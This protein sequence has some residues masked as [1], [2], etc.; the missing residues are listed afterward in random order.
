LNAKPLGDLGDRP[1][2]LELFPQPHLVAQLGN[3]LVR[4]RVAVGK[5][6]PSLE[7]GG[8]VGALSCRD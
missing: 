6:S 2:R 8:G 5:L 4:I 7:Q 3:S 1:A